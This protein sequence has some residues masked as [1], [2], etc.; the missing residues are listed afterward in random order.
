M[1]YNMLIVKFLF[2]P[3]RVYFLNEWA[4]IGNFIEPISV[5]CFFCCKPAPIVSLSPH[6]F[7]F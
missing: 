6:V 3:C 5:E 2:Y 1:V 4:N 7:S